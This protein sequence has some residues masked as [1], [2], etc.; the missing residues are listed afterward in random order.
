MDAVT[1]TATSRADS[2]VFSS[3][4]LTTTAAAAALSGFQLYLPVIT[5]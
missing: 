3:V 2:A 1:I 4:E 5:H